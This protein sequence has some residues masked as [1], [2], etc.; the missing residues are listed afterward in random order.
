MDQV[1]AAIGKATGEQGQGGDLK[2]AAAKG[3]EGVKAK[4]TEGLAGSGG[5]GGGAGGGEADKAGV[6]S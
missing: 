6:V 4:V 5:G 2:D 1:Q 3:L